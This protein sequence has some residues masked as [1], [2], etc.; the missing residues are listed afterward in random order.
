MNK[1]KKQK[2]I[3][4]INIKE[5]KANQRTLNVIIA[6]TFLAIGLVGGYFASINI[7]NDAQVR[8]IEVSKSLK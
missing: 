5:L 1:E 4:E 6:V 8:A 3:K 7:I 2:A